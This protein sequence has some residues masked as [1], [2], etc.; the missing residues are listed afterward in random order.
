MTTVGTLVALAALLWSRAAPTD[1]PPPVVAEPRTYQAVRT[2]DPIDVDGHGGERTWQLAAPDDRF[3]ERQPDLG[4]TP[5]VRTTL[6]VAYDDLALYVLLDCEAGPGDVIVRTLRRDNEGIFSDDTVYVKVDPQHDRRSGYSFGVNAEGAQID[7]LGL[8]DGREFI[9]EWDAVWTAEVDRRHDGYTVEFRIPFAILGLKRADERTMGF[10]ITRDHPSRNATYDWRL[11]V[12]PRSPMAASQFGQLEG[13]RNISGQRAIEL[14]PYGL[15]RTNFTRELT[16][17]PARRPNF[18][19]GADVRVQI[20]AGSYVEASLLT[21]FAQVEADEVQVARDRFPLFFPERRPFFING[22]EVFNFGRGRE[23]QLF[24]SRRVGL[25]GG[26]QVPLLGGAKVYGRTRLVSYGLLHVQ[27]LGSP[28]APQRGLAATDPTSVSVAR[29]RLQATRTFNVGM[30]LL[31]EHRFGAPH[32]DDAAGGVDGQLISRD[33]RLQLYGFVAGTWAQSPAIPE[34]QDALGTTTSPAERAR[35]EIGA[36]AYSAIE[37]RGLYVRPSLLWLW[38]DRDFNPRLGFYRRPGTSRQEAAIDF[39]PRPH[40]LGL[41]EIIFGPRYSIETD[42]EYRQRLGQEASAHVTFNWRNGTNVAYS[43]SNY[44]DRLQQGFTLYQYEIDPML[45]RGFRQRIAFGTPQRRVVGVSGS[46][47]AFAIF[48]GFAH[49]PSASIT[50]RLG[51]HFTAA[52]S[53]THLV[54]HFADAANDFDFGYANANVDVAIN[55][56]L[57]FDTLGRLDLSPGNGHVGMQSRVRWRFLPGS[58]IFLV[59]R[60]DQPLGD[61]PP[62]GL[63]RDPFH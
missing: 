14:T 55:R 34:Q 61:G 31:G 35:D 42:P 53:Y 10:E 27:T 16:V 20:G 1:D 28:S 19:T 12:P 18:A 60:M 3:S 6:K 11:I 24:F 37:Y 9:T 30:M 22:L 29:I 47:E 46:Y 5:P 43:V 13:L 62:G 4:G 44:V 50:A 57:A 48:G 49:Q 26:Q 23:A 39:A 58:D 40:V 59:Y 36:S 2:V 63:P 56:N 25:V 45:Y 38:S 17:D 52:A 15:L 32:S 54:G 41:R 8:E 33:G 7:A 21:D 51:K